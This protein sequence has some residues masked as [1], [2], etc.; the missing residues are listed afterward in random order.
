MM[1]AHTMHVRRDFMKTHGSWECLV[2]WNV[3]VQASQI[4]HLLCVPAPLPEPLPG[5]VPK[6]LENSPFPPYSHG[7]ENLYGNF[8]YCIF[9]AFVDIFPFPLLVC[10]P[11]EC[12]N[13]TVLT[14]ISG[15]S[16]V[17]WLRADL[18]KAL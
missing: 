7:I 16:L 14:S 15:S 8:H 4:S 13:H 10:E 6:G 11:L 12:K 5:S 2:S 1:F 3:L 18:S 17:F 9:R